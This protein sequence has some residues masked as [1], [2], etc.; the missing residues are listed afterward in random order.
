MGPSSIEE[1]FDRGGSSDGLALVRALHERDQ[2]ALA[3][4]VDKHSSWML[5]SAR[6]WVRSR[7]VAEEVVQETWLAALRS[8]DRFEGRSSLRTWLFTILA[9]I[10]RRQA[11][12]E[13]RSASFSDLLSD[14][15]DSAVDDALTDRFFA[16]T[17]PRWPNCWTTAVDA[18]DTL[19]EEHLLAGETRSTIE[20]ALEA[21]PEGQRLVFSLRDLE[22]WTADE[23][24]NALEVSD[25]NQ[26]VLL[27]RARLR[28]RG[29]LERYL[30]MGTA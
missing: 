6:M 27:H 11:I 4:I 7:A 14:E 23:V 16:S 30:E 26:R 15:V 28:I 3:S 13:R 10:A 24:C 5:R 2:A 19:P 20:K 17:H 18:W 25:S 22:G 1:A 29:A 8:L 12:R 9:N 21:L